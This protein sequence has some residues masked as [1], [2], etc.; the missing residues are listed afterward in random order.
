[1]FRIVRRALRGGWRRTVRPVAATAF[2]VCLLSPF[3]V[4]GASEPERQRALALINAAIQRT[5]SFLT[6]AP[7]SGLRPH[8]FEPS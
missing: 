2:W 7:R 5:N 1:M 4:W 8:T 6:S 3:L